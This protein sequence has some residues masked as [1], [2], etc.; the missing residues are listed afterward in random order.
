MRRFYIDPHS[1]KDGIAMMDSNED[2]HHILN[3]LRMKPGDDVILFDGAGRE[4]NAAILEAEGGFPEANIPAGNIQDNKTPTEIPRK[5]VLLFSIKSERE[6]TSKETIS[7]TLYQGFPKHGKLDGI[8]RQCTEL[9]ISAIVPIY[10]SRS[11]PKPDEKKNSLK[12]DRLKK[13]A[14]EAARQSRR[15]S[16]PDIFAP[17]S[18]G[19]A[20]SR[21]QDFD[22]SLFLY[23]DEKNKSIKTVIEAKKM[24]S[25]MQSD[26][27]P[28]RQEDLQG[29]HE[30]NQQQ[31]LLKIA[32]VVGP[33]GGFT[34][35]EAETAKSAGAIACSL[36][37]T[38][39]RTETA[40]PAAVAMLR[41][42]FEL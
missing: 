26:M 40:G 29:I 11:I 12:T 19:E 14:A 2:I 33:E 9:G 34:T 22:L 35:E 10:S 28:E 6:S 27:Q 21:F 39:L 18:F 7:I 32:I 8:V 4:Y 31:S 5:K 42:A 41:Y 16:V 17:I 24:Q 38:I 23:E 25:D 3:V 30:L 13:I 37:T 1:V 36:G 15:A 20:V